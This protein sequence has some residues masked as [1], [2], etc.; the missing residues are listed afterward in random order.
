MIKKPYENYPYEVRSLTDINTS[1]AI[2]I[3]GYAMALTD[4]MRKMS[5]EGPCCKSYDPMM[6]EGMTAHSYAFDMKDNG[7]HH[8]LSLYEDVQEIFDC[9]LEEAVDWIKDFDCGV[10]VRP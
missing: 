5:G 6:I 1:T 4:I 10:D 2:F 7:R 9:L 8:D 3:E